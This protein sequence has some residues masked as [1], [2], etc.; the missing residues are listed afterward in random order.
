VEVVVLLPVSWTRFF[1]VLW[2]ELT[3]N[4]FGRA[5]L[6]LVVFGSAILLVPGDEPQN[7]RGSIDWIGAYLGV[8]G[9][10]L[11]NFVWKYVV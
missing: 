9:L 7:P 6:G 1:Y 2:K 11:F 5:I 3:L 10:I 4:S 8:A